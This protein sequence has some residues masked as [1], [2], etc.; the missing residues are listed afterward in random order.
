MVAALLAVAVIAAFA[1]PVRAEYPEK[2]ITLYV[3]FAPGGSMDS[4]ARA[5]AAGAEKVLG[6]PM[7]IVN[8][9]G[10][11]GTVGLGALAND[12]PDGYHLAAATSTGILRIPLRRKVPYKPLASFTPI[13]GYA[14]V[15]SAVVVNPDSQFDTFEELVEYAREN[16]GKVKYATAGAGS[17]MHL[18]ME[19]VAMQEDIKWIHIPFKGSAPAE[20]ALMGGHVDAVSTG[21]MDKA[22]TGQLK[23]LAVHSKERLPQLPD[24]PTLIELGYDYWNDTI[25]AIYGPAGMDEEMVKVLEDAFAKAVDMPKFQKVADQFL[26]APMKMKSDEYT[27]FLEESW[28][29]QEKL[30][31]SLDLIEEAATRPR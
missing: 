19:I 9:T 13:F 2:P 20:T 30:L 12:P 6:Q 15:I 4:S 5:L 8:K 31:K 22:L 29:E 27:K 26:L 3:V 11:G 23:T 28:P 25:F 14:A 7:V 24:V 17:P 16:P 10:G 1:G 21:D 18:A